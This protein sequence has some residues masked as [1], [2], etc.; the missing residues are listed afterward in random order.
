MSETEVK[1]LLKEIAKLKK[2]IEEL[3]KDEVY[4]IWTRSAFLQF[5]RVMSRGS[6]AVIFLDF[7]RIHELNG[8]V[9]YK[10]VDK[11]IRST[12]D[13]RLR[14]SDL[15]ARWYSGD[16]IVIL[17]DGDEKLANKKIKI[18]RDAASRNGLSFKYSLGTWEVGKVKIEEVVDGLSKNLVRKT[19]TRNEK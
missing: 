15:I 19:L 2:K 6:R 17:L 18:L 10:E 3:S 11:R 4:G 14:A 1:R 8:L 9:G 12:L 16:E 13:I 7:D 5:C